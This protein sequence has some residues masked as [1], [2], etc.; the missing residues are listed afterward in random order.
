MYKVKKFKHSD[1]AQLEQQINEWLEDNIDH[2]IKSFSTV[3]NRG[4]MYGTF[5]LTFVIFRDHSI[6]GAYI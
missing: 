5:F 4:K 3:D 6:K 1:E 2:T